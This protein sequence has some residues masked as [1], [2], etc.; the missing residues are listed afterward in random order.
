MAA[1]LACKEDKRIT[2]R[3]VDDKCCWLLKI[4]QNIDQM[5][6]GKISLISNQTV[7]WNR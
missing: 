5:F 1:I 2:I 3:T 4:D 6:L 7:M